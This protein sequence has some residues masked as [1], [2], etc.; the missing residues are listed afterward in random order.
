MHRKTCVIPILSVKVG[1]QITTTPVD[2]SE[3]KM[4]GAMDLEKTVFYCSS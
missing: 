3:N 2:K 1:N 4:A